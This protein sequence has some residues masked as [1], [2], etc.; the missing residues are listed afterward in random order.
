MMNEDLVKQVVA[1]VWRRISTEES[2]QIALPQTDSSRLAGAR[3]QSP[4]II[5]E[6]EDQPGPSAFYTPWTGEVFQPLDSRATYP[7]QPRPPADHP[8]QEQFNVIEAAEIKSAI[9]ELV[10]FFESQRCTVEKDK[11]CDHCGACR[12]LGF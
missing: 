5:A 12:T 3:P 11:G 7:P 10:E 8:S 2:K 1:N 9:N 4:E 6:D